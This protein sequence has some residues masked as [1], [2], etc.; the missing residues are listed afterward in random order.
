MNE[1]EVYQQAQ[2]LKKM[3][4]G[5]YALSGL[6]PVVAFFIGIFWFFIGGSG[7]KTFN[8][9]FLICLFLGTCSLYV[10][11]HWI[12][13]IP[14]K[15]AKRKI[16]VQSTTGNMIF[17]SEASYVIAR[18]DTIGGWL[19]LT[20]SDLVF[21]KRQIPL[22]SIIDIKATKLFGIFPHQL[23]VTFETEN[24][25]ATNKFFVD[26]PKKWKRLIETN[27]PNPIS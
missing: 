19:M 20:T 14:Y 21:N 7:N 16:K 11:C 2:H 1:Q 13:Y 26:R 27:L 12:F 17:S 9:I 4:Y 8:N 25:Q 24:G 3:R 22:A 5:R 23:I 10:I 18:F 15:N 6:V